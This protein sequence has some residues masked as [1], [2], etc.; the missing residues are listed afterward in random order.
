MIK[1]AIRPEK[2]REEVWATQG[3]KDVPEKKGHKRT[4]N[5]QRICVTEKQILNKKHFSEA[6][7]ASRSEKRA[8]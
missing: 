1:K 7:S 8:C 6:S 5:S 3:L 4:L 2:S